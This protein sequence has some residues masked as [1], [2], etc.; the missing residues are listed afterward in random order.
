M[1]D[2]DEIKDRND[3][4]EVISTF[5]PLKNKGRNW[6]GL[7]PF[8]QEK[9]PSFNVTPLTRSF[10]CFGCGVAGDVYTF[11]EKYNNMTFVEAAE[12]L[13]HRVGL[14]LDKIGGEEAN[15]RA[16]ERELMFAVNAAALK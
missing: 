7:C 2:K 11:I 12:F 6:L 5:V 4:V 15:V 14:S 13:A 3:I 1:A 8:H 16:G 9:T 10:K